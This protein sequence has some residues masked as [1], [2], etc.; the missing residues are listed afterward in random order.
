MAKELDIPEPLL[1]Q[2]KRTAKAKGITVNDYF[3]DLMARDLGRKE[4]AQ[5]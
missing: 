2:V 3:N 4:L 5:S 1:S